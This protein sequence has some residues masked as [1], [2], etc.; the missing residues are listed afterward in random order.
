MQKRRAYIKGG[1]KKINVKQNK[2]L[3]SEGH[4]AT[5]LAR[6]VGCHR[7]SVYRLLKAGGIIKR[8]YLCI[9]KVV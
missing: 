6:Q 5:A 1:K 7:E 9:K 8:I 4:G 2:L 3:K